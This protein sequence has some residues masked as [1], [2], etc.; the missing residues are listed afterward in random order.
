MKRLIIVFVILFISNVPA[1]SQ[2]GM[3]GGQ[4]SQMEPGMMGEGQQMPMMQM[5]MPM[6]KKM[7]GQGMMM[8]DM[9]QMMMD[10]MG[11]QEKMMMGAKPAEKKKM[12]KDMAQMKEKMQKMMSMCKGVMMGGMMGEPSDVSKCRL[13]CSEQWLKKAIDLHEIHIK[14]PKTATEA[15]Q[16]EMMDQMKKAYECITGARCG[17]SGTPS[18]ELESKETEKE[19]TSKGDAHGH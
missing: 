19:K 9:M 4:Q 18:K 1:Y 5:C 13:I 11:M 6:M 17:M 8:Q 7:M 14:D 15:S 16:M 12:M 2:T 3:T 10:M